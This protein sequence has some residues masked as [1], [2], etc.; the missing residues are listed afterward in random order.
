MLDTLNCQKLQ[1]C[2]ADLRVRFHLSLKESYELASFVLGFSSPEVPFNLDRLVSFDDFNRLES[3]ALRMSRSEPLAYILGAVE[4]HGCQIHIN[5]NVLIPRFETELLVEKILEKYP[6]DS[7]INVLDLCTGSGCIGLALKKHRPL[8]NVFMTDISIEALK[9]AEENARRNGLNVKI[10]QGDLFEPLESVKG[11]FDLIVSNPPYISEKE[12]LALE[13]S[14]LDYEPKIA[15]TPGDTGLEIYEKIAS[16][17]FTFL[18]PQGRIALE[19]G[20]NQ[21]DAVNKLFSN[22]FYKNIICEKDLALHD[23]FIFLELQ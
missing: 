12:Y 3:L 13:S 21:K 9:V 6:Q 19:I 17:A 4:F 15:L 5:S 22:G 8:W 7:S 2:L 23:R 14:V 1:S 20:Y 10:F 11:F 16:H 18:K